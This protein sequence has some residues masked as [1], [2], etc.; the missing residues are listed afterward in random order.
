MGIKI[1]GGKMREEITVEYN[2][3]ITASKKEHD[4]FKE[5]FLAIKDDLDVANNSNLIDI[6]HYR[7]YLVINNFNPGRY[8]ADK[9]LP[10]IRIYP[11][12]RWV[13]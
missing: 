10:M 7:K 4:N 11:E 2:F 1:R 3:R 12:S 9:R 13:R 5:K 6:E 8:P